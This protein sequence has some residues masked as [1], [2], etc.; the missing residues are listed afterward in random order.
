MADETTAERVIAVDLGKTSLRVGLFDGAALVRLTR[1]EGAAGL[2]DRGAA[3]RLMEVFR[4]LIPPLLSTSTGTAGIGGIGVGAAGAIAAP[5]EAAALAHGLAEEFGLAAAVA[6][7]AVAAHVGAFGGRPG[8][9]LIAGT[10]AVAFGVDAGGELHQIDG[11]GPDL[12]DLGGGSWIGRETARAVLRAREGRGPQTELDAAVAGAIPAETGVMRWVANG[13]NPSRRLASLAPLTL[14]AAAHG[15]PVAAQIVTAAIEHLVT[16]TTAA[17]GAEL[18][19]AIVGGLS[20]DPF[21]RGRL[22]AAL[23]RAQRNPFPPAGSPLE[24]AR[25]IA[26]RTGLPQERHIHRARRQ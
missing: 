7:D 21:F 13:T 19:V 24:G 25:I 2:G 18:P 12:G 15:E 26:A 8:V 3:G 17:G 22:E 20:E 11:W 6:S 14:A 1:A 16:T 5:D 9:L 4:E 10:G 23:V